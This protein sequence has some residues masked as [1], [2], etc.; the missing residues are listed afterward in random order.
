MNH[1]ESKIHPAFYALV[2]KALDTGELIYF[3]QI[4]TMLNCNSFFCRVII[5]E[6]EGGLVELIKV[7]SE[8]DSLQPYGGHYFTFRLPF[9]G[10]HVDWE[11][12]FNPDNPGLP[13]DF[14]C[15]EDIDSDP[16]IYCQTVQF[17]DSQMD[18]CLTKLLHR[19]SQIYRRYQVNCKQCVCSALSLPKLN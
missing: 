6:F 2:K 7:A 15:A 10:L 3:V 14:L 5:P 12:L 11:L 16:E 4:S 17:W 8:A 1:E 13:P 9:S 19:L 18:D